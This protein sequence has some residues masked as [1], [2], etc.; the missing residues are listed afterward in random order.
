MVR[1]ISMTGPIDLQ[2]WRRCSPIINVQDLC[3]DPMPLGTRVGAILG[4]SIAI[5][6]FENSTGP[7]TW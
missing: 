1:G 4:G 2:N 7:I 5:A 3:G 6:R